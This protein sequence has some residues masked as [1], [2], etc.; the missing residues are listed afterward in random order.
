MSEHLGSSPAQP[1]W[2][3][4]HHLQEEGSRYSFSSALLPCR[5]LGRGSSALG[6]V[7]QQGGRHGANVVTRHC[8]QHRQVF[9]TPCGTGDNS[10]CPTT[11][12]LF[13]SIGT[14]CLGKTTQS[15]RFIFVHQE[16]TVILELRY[17]TVLRG[18]N[19]SNPA[20]KEN[21]PAY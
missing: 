11:L 18:R 15:S 5:C 20:S 10:S 14:G 21:T 7:G 17:I 4:H 13:R 2:G 8:T 3:R 19:T 12:L 16:A 6:A 9:P 1:G